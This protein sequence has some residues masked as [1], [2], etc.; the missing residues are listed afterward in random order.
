MPARFG[1]RAFEQTATGTVPAFHAEDSGT[2][3]HLIDD[4]RAVLQ[5][6]GREGPTGW[7][8][9]S[10]GAARING[11][12]DFGFA[13]EGDFEDLLGLTEEWAHVEPYRPGIGE[14][15]IRANELPK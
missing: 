3:F 4:A 13:V 1:E 2:P 12:R 14:S 15:R 5:A 10:H 11:N 7:I 8:Y 6:K 9:G